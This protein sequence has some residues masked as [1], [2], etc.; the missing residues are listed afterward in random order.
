MIESILLGI[1][2]PSIFVSQRSDGVWDVVDGLQRLA[3]IFEF[4]GLLKDESGVLLPPSRLLGTPYLP[5]LADKAWDD[6]DASK[7][8]SQAQRIAFKREKLDI[9]I[10]K[11]ESD[12]S[13]KYELFQR[14]NTLGSSLSQQEV[15]NCL[16][17]ML[18]SDFF[19]WL[20]DLAKNSHS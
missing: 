1:P 13:T 17:I 18:N 14:L 20:S 16:L 5:A 11:K 6:S 15:R 7:S 2:I 9:K 12:K 10:I 8:F 4:V 19:L 3:T